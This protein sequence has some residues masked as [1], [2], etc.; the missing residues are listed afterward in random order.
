MLLMW[1]A[2]GCRASHPAP[3][4]PDAGA[5]AAAAAFVAYLDASVSNDREKLQGLVLLPEEPERRQWVTDLLKKG[6][7]PPPGTQLVSPSVT[8]DG[9]VALGRVSYRL[10]DGSVEPSPPGFL[11]RRDN[12]W[13]V[14]VDYFEGGGL[15]EAEMEVV[16]RHLG[17]M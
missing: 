7:G 3:T 9:P 14:V 13:W 5:A 8:M 2:A 17:P 16:G 4:Q 6:E 15:T 10:P 12:R 11:V 1:V